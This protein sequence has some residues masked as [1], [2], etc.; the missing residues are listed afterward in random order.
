MTGRDFANISQQ[1][2]ERGATS[3]DSKKW[4]SFLILVPGYKNRINRK[5]LYSKD[6]YVLLL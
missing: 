4:A 2:I 1:R 3:N 5:I 6:D